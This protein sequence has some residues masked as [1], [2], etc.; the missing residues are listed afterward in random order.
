M[1]SWT[2]ERIQQ[3]IQGVSEYSALFDISRVDYKDVT[4]HARALAA[5]ASTLPNCSKYL[6]CKD[7]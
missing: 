3:V 5:I 6:L 7:Y 4:V 2:E 1:Y